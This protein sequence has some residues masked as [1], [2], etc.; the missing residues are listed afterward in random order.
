VE[1]QH[2]VAP[3]SDARRLPTPGFDAE[4][5]ATLLARYP[6]GSA[7]FFAE[8]AQRAMLGRK[9]AS[10]GGFDQF[11]QLGRLLGIQWQGWDT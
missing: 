11:D 2:V 5:Y 1:L 9:G 10:G 8:K 6:S 4:T 7:A 3:D